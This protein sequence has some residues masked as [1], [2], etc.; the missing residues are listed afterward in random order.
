MSVQVLAE[1]PPAFAPRSGLWLFVRHLLA[2]T[3]T[4]V[5][6]MALWAVVSAPFVAVFLIDDSFSVSEYAGAALWVAGWVCLATLAVM[7]VAL[8]LERIV[9]RGGRGWTVTAAILPVALCVGIAAGVVALFKLTD[10]PGAYHAVALAV[11]GM[12]LLVIYWPTV[13]AL[14]LAS[15]VLRRVRRAWRLRRAT[16]GRPVA[17]VR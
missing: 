8:G 3:V 4:V 11:F 16:V 1:E 9:L 5:V 14:N 6:V 12:L 2:A 7:P 15:Y 17:T 13:W 10:A